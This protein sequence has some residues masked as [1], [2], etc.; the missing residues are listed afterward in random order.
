LQKLL[1]NMNTVEG[2]EFLIDKMRKFKTNRDFID[3]MN[4][5]SNG[6]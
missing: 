3:S 1:S 5:K 2:I 6:E 4:K